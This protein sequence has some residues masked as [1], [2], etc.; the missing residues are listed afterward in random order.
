MYE[1]IKAR[2][3]VFLGFVKLKVGVFDIDDHPK[4][5]E[6]F[7]LHYMHDKLK[8]FLIDLM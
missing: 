7:F 3:I 8:E 2:K 6:K 5:K 4:S 1:S